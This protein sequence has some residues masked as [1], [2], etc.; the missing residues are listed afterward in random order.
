MDEPRTINKKITRGRL[1]FDDCNVTASDSE[2]LNFKI[3]GFRNFETLFKPSQTFEP[4]STKVSKFFNVPSSRILKYESLNLEIPKLLDPPKLLTNCRIFELIRRLK[5]FLQRY[6]LS[7]LRDT[8]VPMNDC[9]FER[10][11]AS[12]ISLKERRRRRRR[13]RKSYLT[14]RRSVQNNPNCCLPVRLVKLIL[15]PIFTAITTVV[16]VIAY[17][18]CA[19]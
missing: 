1:I 7:P 3:P 15:D 2:L 5:I 12:F 14:E 16:D 8:C 11:R 10:A 9:A 13:G 18:L 4:T 6:K 19:G 17:G